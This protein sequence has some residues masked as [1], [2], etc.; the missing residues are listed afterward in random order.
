VNIVKYS[1]A[2]PFYLHWFVPRKKMMV[3]GK[4][5]TGGQRQGEAR[6]FI[7]K[8]RLKNLGYSGF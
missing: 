1:T 2:L 7:N 5:S 8:P 3:V 6:T 4:G